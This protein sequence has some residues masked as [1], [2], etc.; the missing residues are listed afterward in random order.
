MD[1]T[2]RKLLKMSGMGFGAVLFA[3]CAVP[4]DEFI[5]ESPHDLP[6]DLV[7][8]T[9]AHYAT[10]VNTSNG[11]ESVLVRVMQG[12]AK[13]IEGNPDHPTSRGKHS[14]R[15]EAA[16]QSLYHPDRIQNPLKKIG[17]SFEEITWDEALEI[18][19]DQVKRAAGKSA[20][21]T[22]PDSSIRTQVL[23]QFTK[24]H[25]IS[26]FIFESLEN[27]NLQNA[28]KHVFGQDQLPNFDFQNSSYILS[29]GADFLGTWSNS[30]FNSW[31]YGNFRQGE[32]RDRGTLIH[33]E[34]RMSLTAANADKW[35]Y[36]KPGTE[37]IIALTIAS[38]II[39]AGQGNP[40]VSSALSKVLTPS[41][42]SSLIGSIEERTG[43]TLSN[44]KD[45]AYSLTNDQPAIIVG[46]GLAG[47]HT[48]GEDNLVAIYL[49]NALADTIGKTG[50]I[51]Y[52]PQAPLSGLNNNLKTTTISEWGD[53]AKLMK[54]G[55]IELAMIHD[56]NPVYG[57]PVLPENLN[58]QNALQSVSYI[59]SFSTFMDETTALAD[60]I[61]PDHTSLESWNIN[62]S[63]PGPGFEAIGIQQPV[64]MPTTNSADFGDILLTITDRLGTKPI[65]DSVKSG[66][67]ENAKT[68]RSIMINENRGSLKNGENGNS[69]D[70]FWVGLLQRGG[71]WDTQTKE[72]G[73]FSLDSD[74]LKRLTTISEPEFSGSEQDYPFHLLPFESQGI[75]DGSG[76]HLP[77]LQGIPDPISTAVWD[78]W[79]EIN[80]VK[81]SELGLREGDIVKIESPHGSL[82]AKIYIHPATSPDVIS[83]PLGQG[84]KKYGRYAEGIGSNV[85]S[86][87]SPSKDK[88]SGALAWGATRVSLTP[89]GV[90]KRLP[91]NEGAIE[92][93]ALSGFPVVQIT[94]H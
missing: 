81:A 70:A 54:N 58:F 79:V 25:D 17:D 34:P 4:E 26:Q 21:I 80:P 67:T 47:A 73:Q 16:L 71:W 33:I 92:A 43:I 50:G 24:D 62:T 10:F 82:E 7:E 85:L 31:Q 52:N 66:V 94:N 23:N 76:A 2:R 28:I 75:G 59:V 69:F 78:T 22:T 88:N 18:L 61:L 32:K 5:I 48:N 39:D 91:K 77:W 68:L 84:H 72:M 87:L 51:Q 90:R 60:L 74:S 45:I 41:V 14:A 56:A 49:L 15:A 86:I 46:G 3:G 8:G 65:W 55:Q 53:L 37:G 27:T 30:V 83:I 20:F 13:K 12:R 36:N 57:L 93:R 6:E 11:Y 89:T 40:N 1:L 38:V 29:F 44:I 64:V 63:N 19:S 35:L 9:D 42:R